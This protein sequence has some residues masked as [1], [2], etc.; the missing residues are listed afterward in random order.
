MTMPRRFANPA[1]CGNKYYAVRGIGQSLRAFGSVL[2]R[3]VALP[4][5]QCTNPNVS[6]SERTNGPSAVLFVRENANAPQRFKMTFTDS[7]SPS[8]RFI[9]APRQSELE[10]AP[11]EMKMLPVQITVS[12]GR[13]FT[14]RENCWHTA[15]T[16]TGTS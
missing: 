8:K 3:A 10:L 6:V 13:L 16:W 11:R 9:F 4:G 12:G 1:G 5:A 15:S 14:R 7:H 2:T